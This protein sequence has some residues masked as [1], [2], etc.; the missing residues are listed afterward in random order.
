VSLRFGVVGL[1]RAAAATVPAIARNPN[2]TVVAAADTNPVVVESFRQQFPS[3]GYARI[4]DLC[5]DPDV[6]AVYVATP[7]HLH[8][9]HVLT[10]A[11]AR[12][13][14]IV[15]KPLAISLDDAD[16]MIAAVDKAGVQMIVGQSQSYEPPVRA[17]R[18]VVRSGDVGAL[19]MISGWYFN[20]WLY[21]PRLPAELDTSMGGG[22]VF[23]QGAH[24]FDV[25]RLIGGGLVR[26]VRAVTGAWDAARPTEGSYSALLEFNDG[27]VASLVYS[28]NDHFHTVELTGQS[29]GGTR[30][31]PTQLEHAAARK[32]LEASGDAALKRQAAFTVRAETPP[33]PAYFGLIIVSC[34]HADIRQTPTGLR[35]YA[36][37]HI[38]EVQL[39]PGVSGRDLMIAELYDAVVNATPALHTPRWA[40][41]TLEVSLAVLESSLTRQEVQLKCQV[42]TLDQGVSQT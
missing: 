35:V 32:R 38:R 14:V 18:E 15:E 41:A 24:H 31:D 17:M 20:D 19:K 21:R 22:V 34:E 16:H 12:K 9:Q 28:G 7:T 33:Y 11:A 30:I 4:E 39:P 23:R 40:K 1:G 10:A 5:N 6:D 27:V 2:T 26:S 37:H 29:E 3:R 13:H 36:D 42:P 25:A 8:T